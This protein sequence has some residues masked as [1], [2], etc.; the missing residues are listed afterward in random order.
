MSFILYLYKIRNNQL[1]KEIKILRRIVLDDQ[2]DTQNI[3]GLTELDLYDLN[4]FCYTIRLIKK[5]IC[6]LF[7][8]ISKCFM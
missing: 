1:R 6:D 7:F 3:D 4:I 2:I 8:F 5:M